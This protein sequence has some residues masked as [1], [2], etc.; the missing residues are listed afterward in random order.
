[1]SN[2]KLK[3]FIKEFDPLLIICVNA[4]NVKDYE[5]KTEN[6]I[7]ELQKKYLECTDW[8]A[9]S[10]GYGKLYVDCYLGKNL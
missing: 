3:D 4:D 2:Q 5:I 10:F 7:S 8:E 1:M 6:N 9:Q